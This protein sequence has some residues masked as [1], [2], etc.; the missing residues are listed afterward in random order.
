MSAGLYQVNQ[1]GKFNEALRK[2]LMAQADSF[3]Q[4][5]LSKLE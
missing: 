2:S 1:L 3:L 4:E 5:I